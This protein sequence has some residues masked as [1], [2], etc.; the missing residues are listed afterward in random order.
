[1]HAADTYHVDVDI[2]GIGELQRRPRVIVAGNG[3]R[4]IVSALPL[5]FPGRYV[6]DF[7]YADKKSYQRWA[8]VT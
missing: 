2:V 8:R 4:D 1:M 7:V 6:S 5:F 3:S